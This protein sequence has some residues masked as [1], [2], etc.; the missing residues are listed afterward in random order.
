MQFSPQQAA[1]FDWIMQGSGS[2][3]L[4]A[5]AGAGKTT[6]LVEGI[7]LMHGSK[8]FGAYNK[9]IADEI[10]GRVRSPNTTVSTMHSAG[11]RGL[12]RALPRVVVD[13]DKVRGIFRNL[14]QPDQ[15]WARSHSLEAP[16]LKLVSYAKQAGVG[17]LSEANAV[18]IDALIEHFDLDTLDRDTQV[19]EMT[20]KTL[21]A[22]NAD[23][24]LCDFDDMIYLPLFLGCDLPT[25]DW[26][27]I[28]EAQDTNVTRRA[29]ALNMMHANSR[30]VAVGDPR[31]AIYGFTGADSNAIELIKQATNAIELPLTV[32]YRCPK[33]V[34]AHAQQWVSHIE[35][36]PTA[37]EGAV[38][39]L[40]NK[41]ADVLVSP[42]DVVLCRFNAPLIEKAYSYLRD[43]KPAKIEGRDIGANL[44]KI[45]KKLK[46][47]DFFE[48]LEKHELI[49]VSK[50]LAKE[51]TA[52]ADAYRDKCECIRVIAERC[53]TVSVDVVCGEIDKLFIDSNGN[54]REVILLSSIHRS[55]GREWHRVFWLQVGPNKRA[56]KAWEL[57]QEDNLSYVASTRAKSELMLVEAPRASDESRVPA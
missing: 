13:A 47:A 37:P 20:L 38:V 30:L 56:R 36:S 55:K 1:Y 35:A 19:I 49:E 15:S 6:T 14:Y 42:G 39:E 7:G 4:V 43:G 34:V 9:Q 40:T 28:D 10:A 48:A 5:V 18:N 33:A 27:L 31:Q 29:L 45:V 12:R 32:S 11:F 23:L 17:A 51:K 2:V 8:F 22:S 52:L 50:L 44:K 16:V 54:G 26:V 25:Y 41:D 24:S 57:E 46:G 53:E 3:V 21:E